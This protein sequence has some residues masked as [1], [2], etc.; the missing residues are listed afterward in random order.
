[1]TKRPR[2]GHDGTSGQEMANDK[3]CPP[4]EGD[5]GQV[6][7]QQVPLLGHRDEIESPNW[8]CRNCRTGISNFERIRHSDACEPWGYVAPVVAAVVTR[9]TGVRHIYLIITGKIFNHHWTHCSAAR[10]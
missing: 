6:G 4:Q 2:I 3:V 9:A 7:G 1:M 10:E 8:A 5:Q